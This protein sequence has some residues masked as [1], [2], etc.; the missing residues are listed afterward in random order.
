MHRVRGA[1]F[2]AGG[3]VILALIAGLSFFFVLDLPF[4]ITKSEWV[5]LHFY[6]GRGRIFWVR[7]TAI[8]S[9]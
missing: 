9:T 5:M 7:S 2:I 8:P 1:T 4:W 3:V 6:H